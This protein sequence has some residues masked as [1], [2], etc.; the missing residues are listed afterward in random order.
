MM[1]RIPPYSYGFEQADV[2]RITADVG[3]LLLDG[4]HLTMGSNGAALE[5]EFAEYTGRRYAVAVASGT[6]ALEISLRSVDVRGARVIVPTN[7]FGATVVAVLRA[8]GT[9]VFADTAEDL[10]MDVSDVEKK[11]D[12][13]V[14]AVVAVHIGGV[15]PGSIDRLTG[16]CQA[17]GVALVEDAAHA[18]GATHR[19]RHA[20]TFGRAAAFS[21][22]STKVLTS[23]EGGLLVTDD[24]YVRDQA[25][26]LRDHAKSA[27]GTMSTTGYNWRLTE[28]QAIVARV[29]LSRIESMISARNRVMDHFDSRLAGVAGLRLATRMDPEGR[30]NGYKYVVFVGEMNPDVIVG[31][32]EEEYGVVAGGY[33]YRNPCHR[34]AAF[35][36][37]ACGVYR[38]ADEFCSSH[39]CPPTHPQMSDSDAEYVADALYSVLG[40]GS[41]A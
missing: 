39:V 23:G 34:Q 16:L 24:E 5:R 10:S 27:D 38:G 4:S 15:I 21:L 26:L 3:R 8:G 9:P 30:P 22:F 40:H 29:Q 11:I 35:T 18:A 12:A 28:L 14:R 20:G 32:L 7:T 19:G 37:F 17:H 13:E 31:R 25:M 36:E 6:A 41:P 1:R 2:R 33:V